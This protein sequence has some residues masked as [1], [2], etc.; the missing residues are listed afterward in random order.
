MSMQAVESVS[1]AASKP[2]KVERAGIGTIVVVD[3]THKGGSMETK[4]FKL[5]KAG[6]SDL[7]QQ[8]AVIGIDCAWGKALNKRK[9]GERLTLEVPGGA[10]YRLR[11]AR[12]HG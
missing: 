11:I 4:S 1:P 9:V 10:T 8:P 12:I 3:V 6:E 5:A 7:M 2:A